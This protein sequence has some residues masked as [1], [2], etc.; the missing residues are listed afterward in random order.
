MAVANESIRPETVLPSFAMVMNSSP[1]G[2]LVHADREVALVARD[3]R[4]CGS[5]ARRSSDRRRRAMRSTTTGGGGRRRRPPS[6]FFGVFAGVERLAAL[7][8]VAVHGDRLEAARQDSSTRLLDVS[9]RRL[10]GQVDGLGDGAREEVL[11]RAHHL[12]VAPCSGSSG[13]LGG[14]EGAVEHRRGARP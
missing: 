12:D 2:H 7:A 1:A 9:D 11:G 5:C 3:A 14:L 13:A 10:V 6:A 4:T 8:A